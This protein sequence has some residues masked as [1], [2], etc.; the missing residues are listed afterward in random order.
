MKFNV[1]GRD[2]AMIVIG[3]RRNG[4]EPKPSVKVAKAWQ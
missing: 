4:A 2:I 1:N 3:L